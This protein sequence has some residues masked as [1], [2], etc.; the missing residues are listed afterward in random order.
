MHDCIVIGAGPSGMT[1]A[2]YLL[3]A[4]KSVLVL[5]KES[6]GGQIAKSPRLENY[7]SIALISGQEFADNLFNQITDLGAD[8]EPEEVKSV[9]KREDGTF[10][11]TT[12]WGSHEGKTVIIASGCHHRTLGLARED[13]LVGHGLS[14]CAT[15]DGAFFKDKDVLLIGDAN[16]ALQYA[17]V[18]AETS[19]KVTIA[20]LFD[21]FFG[22]D[23]L[24]QRILK[25]PNIEIFHNLNALEF[26]G[27][28]DLTGVR[29]EDTQTKQEKIIS[30]D[31]CFVAIG[32]IPCNE[33]FANLVDL[34]KGFIK[35]NDFMETKTEGLYAVGDCRVKAIRQVI[36]ANADGGI[37]AVA[38]TNY[39]NRK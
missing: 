17:I 9:E 22:D 37:A 21:R 36:T 7:P 30:C 26:L 29:F 18:L 25:T 5:E 39:L 13:Q 32:Q 27:N 16:T 2:L 12:D 38:A 24:V 35:A 34:E 15:C 3:R 14:Y 8:F 28:E 19:K 31:G 6:I 33:P 11:V 10:L 23:I 4:G 1:A 20:T